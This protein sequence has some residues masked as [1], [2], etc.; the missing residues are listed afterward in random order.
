M[1]ISGAWRRLTSLVFRNVGETNVT[2]LNPPAA[3]AAS[4]TIT[5]PDAT[6]TLVGTDN[7]QTLTGKSISGSTNTITNVSLTTGVTG[8]LPQ[9]NGGT[10]Q[11]ST[12]TFP[13]SGVLVT[14]AGTQTLTNKTITSPLGIV[15]GDV[16]L[17]N[18]D[19]TSDA[20][21]DAATATLSNKTLLTPVIDDY[22]DINEEAAPATPSSGKVRLYAKTDKKLYTKDSSGTEVQVGASGSGEINAL[23]TGSTDATGWT[24][25]TSHSVATDTS[26][27]PL[28]P[29]IT[30]SIAMSS[31]AAI[32][33]GSQTSTSGDYKAFTLPVG[34]ENK[35]L[36][37]D[38][39]FT[40]PAATDGTWALAVYNGA[41][42][43]PLT[44]DSSGDTVLPAGTT[45]KFTAYFDTDSANSYSVN[46]VQR[47][48]TNANTLY[49]TSVI[50]G[51][52]IQPQGAVVGPSIS[53]TPTITGSGS[54]PTRGSGFSEQAFW[55]RD[56][57]YMVLQ[58]RY[59]QSSAGS[60][61]SGNYEW[62]LPSGLTIDTNRTP[63]G[64]IVNYGN[65][66]AYNGS[67]EYTG[68]V[69]PSTSTTISIGLFGSISAVSNISASN[70]SFG[71][72]NVRVG[73]TVRIPIAEWAG[74]GTVNLAQNDVEYASNTC[75]E[76]VAVNTNYSGTSNFVYG[77]QGSLFPNIS[78]NQITAAAE[79]SY[80]VQF[81]TPIQ[82]GDVLTLELQDPGNSDNW[83][84]IDSYSQYLAQGDARYG[85]RVVPNTN[86]TR[87]LVFFGNGGVRPSGATYASAGATNWSG[88]YSANL[89]WR[90]R[91]S[92]A[93]AA[94]GFGIVN[95]GVSSGLVSASGLPGR[96]SGTT[97]PTGFVG[98]L[99][100][101]EATVGPTAASV[102]GSPFN[103]GSIS[104][105]AG[106]WLV[107]GQGVLLPGTASGN[108]YLAFDLNTTSAT[109]RD[110]STVTRQGIVGQIGNTST[111]CLPLVVNVSSTQT[112]YIIGAY[113][114]SAVG[115]SVMRAAV[116]AV[117]IA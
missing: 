85:A 115:S 30:T 25:G 95:P 43:V 106:T 87:A 111:G 28:A 32:S 33:L 113:N 5:L 19:N 63:A 68:F 80:L 103:I 12:A 22:Q 73:F 98:E 9:A 116:T 59:I 10:G 1:N 70:V 18:V 67:T 105:S 66:Y 7:T 15:K 100:A 54:N 11:N 46:L 47:T 14:E 60:A 117:R 20:T 2:T 27:S 13:T 38:I 58:Y 114:F 34:L 51:P 56:G 42:R 65:A 8:V 57:E 92:S 104:L 49:V 91:K 93:G 82:S 74:S 45:G 89:R 26:N 48:R 50:V 36:K 41:T 78:T 108:T 96:T 72:T 75:T 83:I 77:P 84:G 61:G 4:R 31:S 24:A 53:Y 3:P 99:L 112:V 55:V 39:Y 79:T 94:V 64:N 21:K 86:S 69:F 44:T 23:T 109:F 76:G 62:S 29:V 101:N 90:V 40:S 102:S 52:G 35:K 17:G 71:N 37:V 88:Y 16:G 110:A 6:T 97:V 81:Q 107:Y